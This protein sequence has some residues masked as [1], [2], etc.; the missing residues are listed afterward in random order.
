MTT[1]FFDRSKHPMDGIYRLAKAWHVRR[2]KKGQ[3][4]VSYLLDGDR[5]PHRCPRSICQRLDAL[6]DEEVRRQVRL[7]KNRNNKIPDPSELRLPVFWTTA[8]EQSLSKFFLESKKPDVASAYVSYVRRIV[9]PWLVRKAH[10]DRVED[11]EPETRKARKAL[12]ALLPELH[13]H[14]KASFPASSTRKSCRQA[15]TAFRDFLAQRHDV[16]WD[17]SALPRVKKRFDA[18]GDIQKLPGEVLPARKDMCDALTLLE[19]S[20]AA[21]ILTALATLGIRFSEALALEINWFHA[22]DEVDSGVLA[23]FVADGKIF[24][25]AKV[26]EATKRNPEHGRE[27]K[28]GVYVAAALNKPLAKLLLSRLQSAEWQS[29]RLVDPREYYRVQRECTALI[30]KLPEP[31]NQYGLHDFRRWSITRGVLEN[32][33]DFFV[34]SQI[35]GHKDEKTT[36]GYLDMYKALLVD[37]R[38]AAGVLKVFGA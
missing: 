4:Y 13:D 34:I 2:G 17:L 6:P 31:L 24:A 9:L 1:N 10:L 27:P 30:R 36:R 28:R 32:P 5:T 15:I 26:R 25:V 18:A 20:R 7:W 8:F 23:K 35:H 16:V 19:P 11:L 38:G 29:A 12:R 33:R 22:Q 3:V 14:I 37:A 21:F